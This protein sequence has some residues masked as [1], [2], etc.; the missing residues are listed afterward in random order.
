MVLFFFYYIA[1]IGAFVKK[2]SKIINSDLHILYLH[3]RGCKFLF[4]FIVNINY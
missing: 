2:N 4:E 1:I 3:H